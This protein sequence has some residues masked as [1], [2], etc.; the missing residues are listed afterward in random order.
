MSNASNRK[1]KQKSAIEKPQLDNARRLRGIFF[2]E[3]DDEELKRVMK[4]ACRKLEIPMPAALPCRLQLN[5]H[6]ETC[7]K[8]GQHKTKYACVVEANECMRIRME[9]SQSTSHEDHSQE[10]A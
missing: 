10:R 6:R 9:G 7:G 3:P 5:Q 8:I 1:S 4:N 2:I